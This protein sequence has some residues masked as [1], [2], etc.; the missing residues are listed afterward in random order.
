MHK[1][2]WGGKKTVSTPDY[3]QVIFWF[4][5]CIF[6]FELHDELDI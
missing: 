1:G 4:L 2:K 3:G 5:D 6:T